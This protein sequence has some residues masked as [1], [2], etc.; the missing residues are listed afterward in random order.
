MSE[1][2]V[3]TH[4]SHPV[5]R[6]FLMCL[7][8][9]TMAFGIAFSIK[10]ELG[11]SPISSAPYVLSLISGLSVGTTTILVNTVF[12]L[13]QVAVLR[14]RYEP[15]QLLQFPM[16]VLF[17]LLIDLA[18]AVLAPLPVGGYLQ[19]WILCAVGIVLV[20]VGVSEEVA[21]KLVTTPGEGLVLAICKVAPLQFGYMKVGFDVAL[22]CISVA[23]SFLFLHGLY[24]V[25]EGTLAAAVCVG[26]I[27]K[28]MGRVMK[29]V[30]AAF[31]Q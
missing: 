4:L 12:I 22:V 14:H 30:D 29:K 25:R 5:R 11:T 6:V 19:K 23:L 27:A 20:G 16:V 3:H 9:A 8:F 1:K 13:S 24:G 10:A 2:A 26:F 18:E 21:A 28:G 7:G 17:G 15:F 31:L